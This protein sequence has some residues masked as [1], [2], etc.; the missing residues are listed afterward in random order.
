VRLAPREVHRPRSSGAALAATQDTAAFAELYEQH[1]DGLYDFVAR[2]VRD[3]DLAGEIVQST[4]AKAW[5][6]LREGRELRQ[7]KAWLYAVARNRALDELR[8]QRRLADEP[9]IYA[10][11][12]PSRL[13][14]PQAVAEDNEMVELVWSSAAA[15]S[16]E[17]YSLLDLHVRHG[18]GAADLSG[19]LQLER[20]AV[21][22]RLS[23]LRNSLEESVAS[24]LLVRRGR[25]D[26]PELQAIVGEHGGG[27]TMTPELRRAVRAHVKDCEI[28]CEARRR[29]VAP[30][31]IFGALTPIVALP[32]VR[33]GIWAA[34]VPG[35]AAHAAGAAA[36]GGTGAVA[37]RQGGKAK[38]WVAGAGGVAAAA[39]VVSLALSSGPNVRD[40]SRVASLDHTVG[41]PSSDPTVSLRWSPGKNAK[42]YSVIFSRDK[43]SEPAARENVTGTQFTSAPLSPGRWWFILRTHGKDGGWTHTLRLGPFV[44]TAATARAS[45]AS[46]KSATK[47]DRHAHRRT[48]RAAAPANASGE[49]IVAAAV[50][51][52]QP[53]PSAPQ[54][55]SRAPQHTSPRGQQHKK[56]KK[57]KTKTKSPPRS[58]TPPKSQTPPATAPPATAPPATAPPAAQDTPVDQPAIQNPGSDNGGGDKNE[59]ERDGDH[60]D[61][62]HGGEHGDDEHDDHGDDEHGHGDH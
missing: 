11:P 14:D 8:R 57:K 61:R 35:G 42:G 17:E 46:G 29:F 43:S 18:L 26:C 2:I 48:G 50:V 37:A 22:T 32:G 52:A 9:L 56:T 7:P 54:A 30:V 10:Q 55:G 40:P 60:G 19:A 47:R 49:A 51:K 39:A 27:E 23:R 34:V 4:F 28:C 20:G 36:V 24:T 12:D 45:R 25:E 62:D 5:D 53:Q 6:E 13:S 33:E 15:L 41:V 44:I 58:G 3:R 38:Y 31:E 16:P 59:G 1:F 21:Y